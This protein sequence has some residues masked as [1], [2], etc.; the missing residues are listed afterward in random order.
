M[1]MTSSSLRVLKDSLEFD[2]DGSTRT[3]HF[4]WLRDNCECAK[5]T[6][7]SSLQKLRSSATIPL[8]VHPAKHTL[9][10]ANGATEAALEVEWSDKHISKYPVSWL[11]ANTYH[12]NSLK[13]RNTKIYPTLW[14]ASEIDEKHSVGYEAFMN[15]DDALIKALKTFID[16]GILFLTNVPKETE[17]VEKVA[18]RIGPI[19]ESFFGRSWD[20]MNIPNAHNIA[21]TSVDLGLHQDLPYFESV[22]PVQMLHCMT[23]SKNGGESVFIDSHMAAVR[24]GEKYPEDFETLLRVPMTFQ[25]TNNHHNFRCLKPILFRNENLYIGV[26]FSPQNHGP[27][28]VPPQDVVPFYTAF[29][30]FSEEVHAKDLVL[31]RKLKEGELVIFDNRRVLHGRAQFDQTEPRHLRGT[32]MGMDEV[33]DRFWTLSGKK[34]SQLGSAAEGAKT[35]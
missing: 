9:L 21:Y 4:V 12:Q 17:S 33:E 25:Y 23:Q 29:K 28:A 35:A 32:Y 2:L 1:T 7:P 22:P 14:K 27:L 13:E 16:Y 26:N 18:T 5:C 34:A 10:E 3:F 6:H 15:N 19:R 24:F 20:V 31:L 11:R 8:D 30:R